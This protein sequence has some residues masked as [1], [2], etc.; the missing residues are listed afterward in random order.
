[1]IDKE[2]GIFKNREYGIF[3][4]DIKTNTFSSVPAEY[5]EPAMKRKTRYPVRPTLVVSLGDVFLLD[6]FLKGSGLIKAVDAT[7]Y[8]NGDTLKALLAYYILSPLA[9][10]H[11]QDW[12]ELTYARYLYPKAQMAS[13]RISDALADIGSEDARRGFFYE[14]FRFLERTDSKA[15]G[16]PCSIG[17]GILID[18]SGLPN[19]IR[20][21]LTAVNTHN[22][23]VSEEVRLI[24][25][26]Q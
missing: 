1:M 25:T 17:D 12:W 18:S 26:V 4:Y 15:D 19:S 9:S 21:P 20:F 10:S 14:Y 13:Q 11:A 22:G 2:H 3:K 6:E 16:T 23:I 7:G 8:R 24:Y 5:Q